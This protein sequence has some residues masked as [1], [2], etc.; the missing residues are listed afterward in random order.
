MSSIQAQGDLSRLQNNTNQVHY[1][2]SRKNLGSDR[3]DR[4]GFIRLILAQLQY[5]DPT[6]PEDSTQMLT[7]QLQLEQADQM[8]TIVDATKFSQAGSMVGKEAML[9]DARW[10]FNTGTTG[11]PEWDYQTN[12]PKMVSGT[13]ESVQFDRAKGKAL[14]NIDGNYYDADN[15]RQIALPQP[16][17]QPI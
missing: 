13:I 10:D 7:Q 6:N 3:L 16:P 12:G 1:Q 15:I 8:K 2:N 11:T 4:E 14:V 17:A 5:Q 9:V